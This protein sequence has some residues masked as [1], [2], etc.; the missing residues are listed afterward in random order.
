MAQQASIV[1]TSML[2][3]F[4]LKIECNFGIGSTICVYAWLPPTQ[5]STRTEQVELSVYRQTDFPRCTKIFAFA[6]WKRSQHFRLTA[7]FRSKNFEKFNA[8]RIAA[9]LAARDSHLR[10]FRRRKS[11]ASTPTGRVPL[12]KLSGFK[13][14]GS[15]GSYH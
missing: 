15:N 14:G 11:S 7:A 12:R 6:S 13:K 3:L 2:R 9:L 8:K 10:M 1:I 4:A 5:R